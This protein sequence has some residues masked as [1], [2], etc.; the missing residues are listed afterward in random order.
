MFEHVYRFLLRWLPRDFRE[1][2]GAEMLDT[3]RALD[4]DRPR[5]LWKTVRAVSDAIVTPVTVTP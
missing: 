2:F 1:R 4:G 5:R 3:A